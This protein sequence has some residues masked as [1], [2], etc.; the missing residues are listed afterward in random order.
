MDVPPVVMV[1]SFNEW[2]DGKEQ[3]KIVRTHLECCDKRICARPN[4]TIT[5]PGLA[6]WV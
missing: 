4:C 2:H 1:N 6:E 5:S 3:C